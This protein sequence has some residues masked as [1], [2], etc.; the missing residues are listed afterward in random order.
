MKFPFFLPLVAD[1]ITS[2]K[3]IIDSKDNS[4]CSEKEVISNPEKLI[5]IKNHAV[6]NGADIIFTPTSEISYQYLEDFG[7]ADDFSEINHDLTKLTEKSAYQTDKNILIGGT[8]KHTSFE[9]EIFQNEHILF[10]DIYFNYRE[11]MTIL[12]DSGADFIFLENP[13]SL[14][15]MRAGVL[16]SDTVDIPVF[17]TMNVD[18]EGKNST[19]TDYIAALITLQSMGVSAFGIKCTESTFALCQLISDAFPHAEIPLIAAVDFSKCSND[20]LKNLSQC[21]ASIFIDTSS[22]LGNEKVSAVK[23]VGCIF[24]ENSEKDSYAAAIDCQAFFLSDNLEFSEPLV[25]SYNLSEDIIDLDD[26][27]INSIYIKLNSTDDAALLADNAAMSRLPTV[28]YTND[29]VTLEAALRYF[30]GRIIV[31]TRCDIDND[32]LLKFSE[33]YGAILY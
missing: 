24:D 7:A 19:G 29:S 18:K 17:I 12:K 3:E 21:G 16:A 26:E 11:Q 9:K 30:P 22:T 20:D 32:I 28:I 2:C 6:K 8:V 15:D 1:G 4:I 31:D 10:E 23:A 14:K 33:K 27:N 25:C 5:K 13:K